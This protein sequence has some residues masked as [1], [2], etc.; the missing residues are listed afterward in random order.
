[1]KEG[2]IIFNGLKEKIVWKSAWPRCLG[3][4]PLG[5]ACGVLAQKV[6]LTVEQTGIMSLLVFAGSGQFIAAAMIGGGA[7][8]ASIVLT[9]FI[10]NL[11]H[12]LYSSSLGT[13]LLGQSKKFLAVFPQ[14]ITDETFAVNMVRFSTGEWDANKA[15]ALNLIAHSCWIFSNM[16]GNIAG[17]IILVDSDIVNYTLTAMFIALWSYNF[18][19]KLM[20]L[21]GLFA[22]VLALLLAGYLDNK[23][24]IVVATIIA[25]TLACFIEEDGDKS[26]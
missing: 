19:N 23:L 9:I 18:N 24:H 15:L 10:V 6:G 11:R 26:E 17:N 7:S 20:L 2:V 3:Y 21:T 4:L 14:G 13:Y 12:L 16:L 22:G 25:A 1:M 5:F 8:I